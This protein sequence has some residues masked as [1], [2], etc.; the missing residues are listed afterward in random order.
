MTVKLNK[1]GNSIALRLPIN[2]VK[3][4]NL[5]PGS[6]VDIKVENDTIII[7]PSKDE[8]TLEWLC[9]DMTKENR[10]E[11]EFP[12]FIGKEKYWEDK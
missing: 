9:E 7:V 8:M 10:H 1:W 3:S 11:E 5:E 4:L 2:V 6:K 12:N